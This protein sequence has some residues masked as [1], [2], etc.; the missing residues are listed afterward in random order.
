MVCQVPATRYSVSE[1]EE[2]R[3]FTPLTSVYYGEELGQPPTQDRESLESAHS[4]PR[5]YER[6]AE[7][8]MGGET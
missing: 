6:T 5:W 7:S 3:Q 1:A 8:D 2:V 4:E